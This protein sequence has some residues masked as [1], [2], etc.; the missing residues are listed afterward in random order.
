MCKKIYVFM[1][2]DILVLKKMASHFNLRK[3]KID[4][5]IISINRIVYNLL[6]KQQL[7]H[8]MV[9]PRPILLFIVNNCSLSIMHSLV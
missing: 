6:K 2:N 1:I 5:L 7:K 3:V 9:L 8:T 4:T